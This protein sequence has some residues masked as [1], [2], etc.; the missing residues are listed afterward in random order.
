MRT[1]LRRLF[2]CACAALV[3]IGIAIVAAPKVRAAVTAALVQV[4]APSRP[5]STLI[6]MPNNNWYTD[7]TARQYGAGSGEL[8]VSA[9]TVTNWD[10]QPQQLW[11]QMPAFTAG[12]SCGYSR[13]NVNWGGNPWCSFLVPPRTTMHFP[14][15]SPLIFSNGCMAAGVA[16]V[17]TSGSVYIFVTGF[18]N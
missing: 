18:A 4:V 9:M 12:Q 3:I 11:I 16:T 7:G 14:F 17:L 1:Y 15:P 5:F 2:W 10:N 13:P 8:A 6:Q